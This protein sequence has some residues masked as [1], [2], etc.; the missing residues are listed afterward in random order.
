MS[1]SLSEDRPRAWETFV[2]APILAAPSSVTG[3]LSGGFV[4]SGSGP[5]GWV[6][7]E[8]QATVF[9]TLGWEIECA[10]DRVPV[11]R[12]R[13]AAGMGR[14]LYETQPTFR[15]TL[16]SATKSCGAPRPTAV[17]G[18]LSQSRRNSRLD[19]TST[20]N[21]RCCRQYALAAMWQSW[22]MFL[23]LC[24][25]QRRRCVAPAWRRFRTREG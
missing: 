20:R 5:A 14:R 17:I 12:P 11:Y 9:I 21:R 10:Q 18:A 1:E 3:W 6:L 19:E 8:V 13:R 22:G 25:A 24:S 2:S 4:L 7:P 23:T 16:G 15:K